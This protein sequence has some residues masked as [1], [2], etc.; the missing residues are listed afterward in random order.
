[1][2]NLDNCR[3]L[4]WG[5]KNVY[6][7]HSHIHEGFYRALKLSGKDVQWLDS[8]DDISNMDLSNTLIITNHDCVNNSYWP[9]SK[10]IKSILP[11]SDECFY[12]IHGLNDHPELL[13]VFRN[14][15]NYI[16]WNVLS[17]R[18]MR[19]SLG[20][21]AMEPMQNEILM[22]DD[23]PF[24][25]DRKHLEFR[26]ATDL[27]PF[28]IEQNKPSEMLSLKR[29]IIN[30]VGTIWHVNKI[31]LSEFSRACKEDGVTFVQIGAKENS[32]V[33]IEDNIKLV[34]DSYMAPAISGTHHLTEGYAPCR[35]FKNISY[36]QFGVTNNKKVNEIFGGKLIYNPDPY[37]L[38]FEAKERLQSIR[39]EELYELM[40]EVASKHTYLNRIE[41]LIKASKMI[42]EN[43]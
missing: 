6:H 18:A 17:M 1:M 19:S 43:A 21:S 34:R 15:K 38:Y 30:W 23:A 35:I 41:F 24:D 10:P 37:K 20:L 39:V 25:L 29:P 32:H 5:Y 2:I 13:D 3:Y 9:W 40:D 31:E 16:S 4:I 7:T 8:A 33:S 11:I 22:G 42:I 26:W 28:E 27:L 14:R 36:G 12:A